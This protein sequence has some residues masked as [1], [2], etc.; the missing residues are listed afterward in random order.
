MGYAVPR[1]HAPCT[2]P[3][4]EDGGNLHSEQPGF[5]SFDEKALLLA[6][7]MR[8]LDTL[9]LLGRPLHW[10][11]GRRLVSQAKGSEAMFLQGDRGVPSATLHRLVGERLHRPGGHNQRIG[12]DP[13][14]WRE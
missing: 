3:H 1:R 4:S 11:G 9:L 6:D 8:G 10:G 5:R 14:K 12:W 13:D 2:R 7:T